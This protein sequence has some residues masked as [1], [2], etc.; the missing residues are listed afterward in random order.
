MKVL[1]LASSAVSLTLFRGRLIAAAFACRNP[2]D[3]LKP[4]MNILREVPSPDSTHVRRYCVAEVCA[5][6]DM[7]TP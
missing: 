6:R 3:V 1:L 7:F 5:K 4:L 2:C